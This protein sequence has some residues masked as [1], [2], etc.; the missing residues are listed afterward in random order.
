MAPVYFFTAR[1]KGANELLETGTVQAA[2]L[3]RIH[4]LTMNLNEQL[5]CA[6]SFM[7]GCI[8]VA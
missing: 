4:Q 2:V 7:K 6:L 1:L 8:K 3:V 5:L